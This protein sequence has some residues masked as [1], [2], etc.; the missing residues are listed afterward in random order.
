MNI[1]MALHELPTKKGNSLKPALPHVTFFCG[2]RGMQEVEPRD[3]HNHY[4]SSI[5]NPLL[6]FSAFIFRYN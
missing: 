1:L 5:L 6:L 4:Q 3:S 2:G